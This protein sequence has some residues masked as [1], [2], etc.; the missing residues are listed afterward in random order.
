MGTSSPTCYTPWAKVSSKITTPSANWSYNE[1][2]GVFSS[3]GGNPKTLTLAPM[4]AADD[5]YD[6]DPGFCFSSFTIAGGVQV[7]P[8]NGNVIIYIT[9]PQ[10]PATTSSPMVSVSGNADINTQTSDA[11][12]F[13]IRVSYDTRP[14]TPPN[15]N[16]PSPVNGQS[17]V[18]ITIAGS[19][20]WYIWM[21][22]PYTKISMGGSPT[23]IFGAGQMQILAVCAPQ[24]L[25]E[26]RLQILARAGVV[27]Q[28]MDVEPLALLNAVLAMHEMAMDETLVFLSLAPALICVHR[29]AAGAPLIRYLE[30]Q[31]ESVADMVAEIR[32]AV[33]YFQS[34]LGAGSAIRVVY[35]GPQ[36]A[37]AE[38][39]EAVD[40][41][42][43]GG[44]SAVDDDLV[45]VSLR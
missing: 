16:C 3:T 21:N 31:P 32:T 28:K 26:Q 45:T 17:C 27:P 37:C 18:G 42:A 19:A 44:A 23:N 9:G 30:N 12:R 41:Q 33:A 43:D 1:S 6:P 7:Y 14:K 2:T 35:C 5:P 25:L 10:P 4:T 24:E 34:Q 11:K 20:A 29:A 15:P 39:Q 40:Q 36:S 13:Q 22:A 38:L 8:G